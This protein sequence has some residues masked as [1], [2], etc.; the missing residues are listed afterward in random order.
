MPE[1]PRYLSYLLRL[2]QTSDKGQTIWRASLESPGTT[3][4]QG[5]ASLKDLMDFLY[6]QTRHC[7]K[8]PPIP[9]DTTLEGDRVAS[10][11]V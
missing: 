6:A 9:Q 3:Q 2:W 7:D 1:Q 4:R 8:Q 5:F 11:K 10:P